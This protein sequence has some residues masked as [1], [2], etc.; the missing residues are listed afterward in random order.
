MSLFYVCRSVED[1][2]FDT[3]IRNEVILSQFHG[4]SELERRGH[5]YELY[6]TST[7]GRITAAY[8]DAQ[9]RGG[10]LDKFVFL[11]GPTLMVD[12][13]IG[14]MTAMGMDH[15]QIVVEDFNLV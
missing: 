13:L 9:V 14:Q 15:G 4:F 5:H 7:Q 12:A 11:C 6:N 8:L 2:A 1:A 3:A 10:I